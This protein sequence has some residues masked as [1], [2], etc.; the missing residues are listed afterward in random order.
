MEASEEVILMR[1]DG[2]KCKRENRSTSKDV[3]TLTFDIYDCD[4]KWKMDLC[5][6]NGTI[7]EFLDGPPNHG[8]C[9]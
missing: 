6:S 1:N 3:F 2:G 9:Q 5:G 4:F 7:L 8:K